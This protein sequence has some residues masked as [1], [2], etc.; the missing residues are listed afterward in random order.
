MKFPYLQLIFIKLLFPALMSVKSLVLWHHKGL[1]EGPA[2]SPKLSPAGGDTALNSAV[3][4]GGSA[5]Q[6]ISHTEPGAAWKPE[7]GMAETQRTQSCSHSL[8]LP[9]GSQKLPFGP[10]WSLELG[11]C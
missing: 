5:C 2:L 6:T 4:P 8:E 10:G 11:R 1:T 3:P 7:E 9:D